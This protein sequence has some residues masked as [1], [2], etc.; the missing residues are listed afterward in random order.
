MDDNNAYLIIKP[1]DNPQR[2]SIL[3]DLSHSWESSP[4][5]DLYPL[6]Q[7][8][9]FSIE[10]GMATAL[11]QPSSSVNQCRDNDPDNTMYMS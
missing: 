4:M 7:P 3:R 5:K 1:K 10:F 9:V 8:D 2:V 6:K 11:M